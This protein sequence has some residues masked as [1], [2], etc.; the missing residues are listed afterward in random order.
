MSN[1]NNTSQ[2]PAEGTLDIDRQRF[3]KLISQL[4]TIMCIAM[5]VSYI[6]QIIANFTGSPVSPFQPLV[7][8]INATLWTG[9]GSLKAKK[10]W[11]VII[12]NVPG[13][14]FGIFTVI[15]VYVH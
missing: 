14:I 9:Y 10:D 3:L 15:T 11:P 1:A 13:I 7:A 12:S 2:T 6:P 5:Y 4:A 8:T